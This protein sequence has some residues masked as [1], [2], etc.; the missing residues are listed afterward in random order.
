[1]RSSFRSWSR[2]MA[3]I[4]VMA[5]PTGLAVSQDVDDPSE[6]VVDADDVSF[7]ANEDLSDDS[8]QLETDASPGGAVWDIIDD[9]ED[10]VS[11][12]QTTGVFQDRF[13]LVAPP[14]AAAPSEP[15]QPGRIVP[16]VAF[17]HPVKENAAKFQV[18]IAY[19]STSDVLPF[20]RTP[21]PAGTA[22]W[23]IKHICGGA[24]IDTDWVLTAAHCVH[25][26]PVRYHLTA[27][28]GAEDVSNPNDGM[29]VPI[30]RIVWPRNFKLQGRNGTPYALD[31]ALLHLA[32]G[33]RAFNSREVT[34]IPIYTGPK[35]PAGAAVS[36]MGWGKT[37]RRQGQAKS[38][39]L[40]RGDLK[41][42]GDAPCGQHYGPFNFNGATVTPVTDATVCAG[43]S[44][45]KT[46]E[47]DSGG[48]MIITN[49]PLALVGIVSWN[50]PDCRN[51]QAPGMYTRAESYIS[52]GW[53]ARAKAVTESNGE[54]HVER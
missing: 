46:C 52:S 54:F 36:V 19:A 31:I 27:V 17:A 33:H 28:L 4:I 48:P 49:G 5:M 30:D 21:F 3:A 12:D 7:N 47:G 8:V 42:I 23:E 51:V 15:A 41:I 11:G 38:A 13:P 29:V 6:A 24:L 1:M 20:V 40:M 16:R 53:I 50:H 14:V 39:V 32:P 43:E 37:E 34:T 35:P 25:D 45:S 22:D 2:L 10:A 44:V 26:K 9:G 18:E